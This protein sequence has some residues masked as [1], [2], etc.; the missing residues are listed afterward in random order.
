M[1][2]ARALAKTQD[3]AITLSEHARLWWSDSV[4]AKLTAGAHPLSPIVELLAD[5]LLKGE[6]REMVQLRLETWVTDHIARLLEPVVALRN[7]AEA[8]SSAW[9]QGGLPGPARG[10]A[11]RLA[12]NLGQLSAEHGVMPADMR[13]AAQTL[14]RFGVRGGRRCSSPPPR[15]SK[16]R[17]FWRLRPCFGPFLARMENIPSPPLPGLTS[18]ALDELASDTPDQF[19]AAAFFRKIAGRAVRLDILERVEETLIDAARRGR[20]ADETLTSIVSLMGCAPEAALPLAAALGWKREIRPAEET[21]RSGNGCARQNMPVETRYARSRSRR[22]RL[23]RGL[24]GS[25]Q[26]TER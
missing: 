10:L 6:L 26:R 21:G 20:D 16:T 25:S 14:K 5:D 7:A 9:D 2:R 8:R 3:T 18:F 4:V 23:L 12:E 19:L 22:T 17:T 15:L 1:A 24:P 13:E 11:F